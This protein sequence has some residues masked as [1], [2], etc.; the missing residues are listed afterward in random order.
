M[1]PDE[2]E[3]RAIELARRL[4]QIPSTA[5]RLTKLQL[6]QPIL[7][8]AAEIEREHDAEVLAVWKSPASQQAIRR[9]LERTVGGAGGR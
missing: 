6:A 1:E 5:F 9:F 2:L 4:G 8:A 3:E 7:R